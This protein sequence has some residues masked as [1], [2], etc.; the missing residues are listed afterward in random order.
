[1]IG[2]DRKK[3]GYVGKKFCC[4]VEGNRT[5]R[6]VNEPVHRTRWRHA[7]LA[8]KSLWIERMLQFCKGNGRMTLNVIRQK[9]KYLRHY[10]DCEEKDVT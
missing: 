7:N 5:F 8:I 10:L 6:E 2:C 4:E 9:Q 3:K 1:M